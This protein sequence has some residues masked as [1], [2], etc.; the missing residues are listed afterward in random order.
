MRARRL[1]CL[2]IL[3]QSAIA[4]G[5]PVWEESVAIVGRSRI[6]PSAAIVNTV[7]TDGHGKE[8]GRSETWVRFRP[9]PD[10]RLA[11]EIVFRRENGRPFDERERE[12][13]N[14]ADTRARDRAP[15][16]IDELPLS[17]DLQPLV[18]YRRSAEDPDRVTFEFVLRRRGD[19]IVGT[20][21]TAPTGRPIEIEFEPQPLPPLF[22]SLRSTLRFG[23]S[24]GGAVRLESMTVRG[25]AGAF[26]YRRSFHTEYCFVE[27]LPSPPSP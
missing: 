22:H 4:G 5:D 13:K 1:A 9:L 8:I 7:R 23:A 24:E 15:F 21:A 17:P 25:S 19:A 18:S 20:I 6:I 12:R 2:L 10:G 26:W 16:R 11:S 27:T 3:G 14:R